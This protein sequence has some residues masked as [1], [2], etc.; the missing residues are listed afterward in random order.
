MSADAQEPLCQSCGVPL[1]EGHADMIAKL[2]DGSNAEYCIY[3]WADGKYTQPD[4]TMEDMVAIG[5]THL[6]PQMGEV[7]AREHLTERLKTLKRWSG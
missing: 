3:C 6:A 1:N 7:A 4:A 5:V 2:P